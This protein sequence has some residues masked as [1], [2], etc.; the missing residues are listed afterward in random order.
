M[1]SHRARSSFASLPAN[2]AARS[3][4]GARAAAAP[5]VAPL[6][7][8]EARASPGGGVT[9][10]RESASFTTCRSGT[11]RFG[12]AVAD[13]SGSR[14]GSLRRCSVIGDSFS[15][16]FFVDF[17]EIFSNNSRTD[18][19]P[20]DASRV[21]RRVRASALVLLA[22]TPRI[23]RGSEPFLFANLPWWPALVNGGSRYH[24]PRDTPGQPC[25]DL[26]KSP[27]RDSRNRSA[28]TREPASPRLRADPLPRKRL[29]GRLQIW[30]G[31]PAT[32]AGSDHDPPRRAGGED[33]D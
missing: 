15:Y 30:P 18:D 22:S 28:D 25:R 19:P 12:S 13:R 5:V 27:W 20:A 7:T 24:V 23:G 21:L 29:R 11:G 2:R 10:G 16:R 4:S 9:K 6:A 14:L 8:L 17:V 33:I 26:R 31:P 32:P 3:S 1:L